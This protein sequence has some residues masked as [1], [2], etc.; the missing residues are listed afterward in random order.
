MGVR[1]YVKN[2]MKSNINVKAWTSWDTV[3]ANTKTI[4]DITKDLK[5]PDV[6]APR[7]AETF[8]TVVNK[9]GL[10]EVDVHARMRSHFFVAVV[11]TLLG[12]VSFFWMIFLFTK[13]MYLSGL[14]AFSVSIL[15]FAY[16]FSEHFKYFQMKQKKLNCTFKEWFSGFLK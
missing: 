5:A 7:K 9:L 6:R 4:G 8:E 14:M 16:A 15:M 1:S 12:M 13:G 3:K 11:C 10:S 2:T